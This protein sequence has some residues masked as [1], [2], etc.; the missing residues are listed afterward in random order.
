MAETYTV[1]YAASFVTSPRSN[2]YAYGVR[3]RKMGFTYT[4]V[5]VG[6]AADTILIGKLPPKSTLSMWDSWIRWA[7][8]TSGATFSLGWQAYVDEDGVTQAASAAGLLSAVA[9]TADGGWSHG[10]LVVA[11]P[12]DSIPVVDEKVFNNRT[13]VTLY[14]TIN[15]QAPGVGMTFKGRLG[16]Y[17]A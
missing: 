4:Q 16:F 9:M 17:T 14:A 6:A 12:D 3:L 11:T 13:P 5:L 2:V 8:A 7:T 15:T 10:M 1:E